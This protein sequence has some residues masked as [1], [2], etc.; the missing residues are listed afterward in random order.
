MAHM[1]K[2]SKFVVMCYTGSGKSQLFT[3]SIHFA[4]C[5]LLQV[6]LN[7]IYI[8]VMVWLSGNALALI[9]AV[10][11]RRA[12][13]VLGWVGIPS[14]YLTQAYSAWPSLRG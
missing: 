4:T 12:R 3:A 8:M 10:A 14:W 6:I 9:I 1:L 7:C 11:L 13:L 2:V 5:A